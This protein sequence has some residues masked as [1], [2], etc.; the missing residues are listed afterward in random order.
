MRNI[1]VAVKMTILTILVL[2]GLIA[3]STVVILELRDT[4]E[5]MVL[6]QEQLIREDYDNNIKQQVQNVLSMLEK[7][8]TMIEEGK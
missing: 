1:S 4:T 3:I 7:I 2:V 5:A 6:E 8:N